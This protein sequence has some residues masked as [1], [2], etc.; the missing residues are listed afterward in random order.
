MNHYNHWMMTFYRNRIMN[1]KS[2]RPIPNTRSL[3]AKQKLALEQG[4]R[5]KRNE[6]KLALAVG[7]SRNERK[8]WLALL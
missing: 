6:R 7:Q 3:I 5:R 4:S 2:G 8:L 1:G